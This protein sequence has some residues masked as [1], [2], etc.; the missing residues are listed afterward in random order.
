MGSKGFG[1]VMK[2]GLLGARVG[3]KYF[4]VSFLVFRADI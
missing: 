4:G 3:T 1:F 2:D